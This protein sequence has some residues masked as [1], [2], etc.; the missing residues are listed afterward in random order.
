MVDKH[1]RLQN[2]AMRSILKAVRKTSTQTVRNERNLLTLRN[3]R[4][5]LRIQRIF[6]IVHSFCAPSS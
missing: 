3:R 2:Y 1:E 6:E 4:R 5:F